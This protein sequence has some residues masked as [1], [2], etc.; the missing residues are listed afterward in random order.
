MEDNE[1]NEY[2]IEFID[3]EDNELNSDEK[4]KIAEAELLTSGSKYD[5]LAKLGEVL[6]TKMY[7]S[8]RFGGPMNPLEARRN[9][10]AFIKSSGSWKYLLGLILFLVVIFY[11][12][13]VI[14]FS[15]MK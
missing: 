6:D 10:A 15:G 7:S 8:G 1:Y 14:V 11:S 13:A 9:M 2:K 12:L 5:T 3:G 4:M